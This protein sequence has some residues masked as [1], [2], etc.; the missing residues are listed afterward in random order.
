MNRQPDI[1]SLLLLAIWASLSSAQLQRAKQYKRVHQD[2]LSQIIEGHEVQA[3]E[4][5]TEFL[6]QW[7]DDAESYYMLTVAHA[8]AGRQQEAIDAAKKAIELGLPG[9]RFIAGT[10]T[11]LAGLQD[12]EFARDLQR[13]FAHSPL[14]GPMLGNVTGQ[15]ASIWLRTV[16]GATVRAVAGIDAELSAAV[17]SEEV[18]ATDESDFTVVVRL[19]GLQPATAYH[20]QLEID[21][22][23]TA[24][25]SYQFKTLPAQHRPAKFRFVFGGGAGY[26]PFHER[27]WDTIRATEP[28]LMLLLGDNI[29]SDDPA[30]PEMQH[31][32]YYRRQSRPEFRKLVC[33]TPV[34]T[35]WDDHDFGKN[36]C[37]EGPL[38][39]EPAWKLPVLEVYRNNWVNP[40]Y[41]GGD[42]RPGCYYDF[43]VGDVHF[44]MLDGR[45]YRTLDPTQG[46]PTMLGPV[47]RQWLKDTIDASR[48]RLIMLCS[49]VPWVFKAKGNSQDTWNGFRS[50]RNEIFDYLAQQRKDGVVLVSADRHRSDLWRINRANGYAVYELNSSRLTNQHVHKEMPAA[51]FSYNKKQSFG[52]VDIDTTVHDPTITYRIVT[53][54]GEEVFQR[55]FRRSEMTQSW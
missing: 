41:G 3:R 16:P 25:P 38:I 20:Y 21:G 39:S 4:M 34:F 7:P 13:R 55:Q 43:Y 26:V 10:K 29:Y 23:R 2:A 35:I 42:D 9:E 49:P 50:E 6:Q 8:H 52:V 48:G 47:Q 14:H 33:S 45:F 28:D 12:S 32:C 24:D 19:S 54:D 27:M 40:A 53:I 44:I 17:T 31:Y 46:G 22:Q 36:D 15:A 30:S 51:E 18:T 5:L 1:L 37:V 11:L